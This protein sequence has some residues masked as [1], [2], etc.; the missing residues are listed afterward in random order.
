MGDLGNDNPLASRGD[1]VV[2]FAKHVLS[3]QQD[4]AFGEGWN[5]M[6]KFQVQWALKPLLSSQE[7]GFG[8][9]NYGRAFDGSTLIGDQCFVGAFELGKELPLP[10]ENLSNFEIFVT[11]DVGT[12]TQL[13]NATTLGSSSSAFSFGA[14]LRGQLFDQVNFSV[15]AGRGF[16]DDVA[17]DGEW[18]VFGKL[19]TTF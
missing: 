16:S 2:D 13:V 7:C 5:L 15:E 9:S 18:R 14:G 17:V 3:Y 4:Q 10:I 11:G 8:G 12:T 1:G 19:T 6:T